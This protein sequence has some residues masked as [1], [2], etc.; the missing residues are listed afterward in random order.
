VAIW[1]QQSI[2]VVARPQAYSGE[3]FSGVGLTTALDIRRE[4]ELIPMSGKSEMTISRE[5]LIWVK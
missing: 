1:L 5:S 3:D 2:T 4:E